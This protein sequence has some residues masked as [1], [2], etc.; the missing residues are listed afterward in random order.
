MRTCM[1]LL[2]CLATA[3]LPGCETSHP[4]TPGR[5]TKAP[6]IARPE[7]VLPDYA[8]L[9]PWTPPVLAER[10]IGAWDFT[11][12]AQNWR[13]LHQATATVSAGVLRVECT[14]D[15]PALEVPVNSG[16][17]PLAVRWR[18]RTTG[19]GPVELF[20]T[21]LERPEESSRQ[22]IRVHTLNDGRWHEYRADVL[23]AGAI[24][25]LRFDPLTAPGIAEL[26]DVRVTELVLHPI[27]FEWLESDGTAVRG[28]VRN[29][30]T[31]PRSITIAG[32]VSRAD[33]GQAI[34]FDIPA[35]SRRPF[36]EIKIEVFAEGLPPLTRFIHR[37]QPSARGDVMTVK[38]GDVRAEV[39]RDGSGA[40]LLWKDHVVAIL[41]PLAQVGNKALPLEPAP[42]AG[43]GIVFRGGPVQRLELRAEGGELHY[44][45]DADPSVTGPAL[46]VLGGLE[47][48]LLAGVEHLG[49]G[50]W[51][52]SRLD[53]DR[54]ERLRYEPAPLL[55]TMPLAAFVTDRGSA[56]LLW[57]DPGIQPMFSAP[58]RYD[59][60]PDHLVALCGRTIHARIR[61]DDSFAA[62]GRLEDAILWAVGRRGLP[63]PPAPPRGPKEERALCL[64]ALTG[65]LQTPAGWLATTWPGAR[66]AFS[67]EHASILWRLTGKV[68]ALPSLSPGIGRVENHAAFL[69]SGRAQVWLRFIHDRARAVRAEQEPDG[70]F[71]YRGPYRR[72]HFEDTASG[73]CARQAVVLLEHA[74]YTGDGGSR[75]AGVRALDYM[76][77]FRTPR[78][79]QT[80]EMPLH[81]PDLAACCWLVRA[82]V[83]GYELTGRADFLAEAR[84]WAVR[85]LPF[86][87]QWGRFPVMRYTA[88][89]A[90]GATD[91]T[92]VV[93]LGLPLPWCG[94]CYGWALTLLAPYDHTFD[95][96]KVARGLLLAAE[97]MQ[98]ADGP[99]AGCLPDSYDLQNQRR[100]PAAI[101]PCEIA[102]LALRLDGQLDGLA[103][104]AEADHRIVAPF[105]VTL[106]RGQATIAGLRGTHY[107]IV[108]DGERIVGIDSKGMDVLHL[109]RPTR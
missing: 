36:E 83:R 92:G 99:Y 69:V 25:A 33:P 16:R 51:S 26:G 31:Q 63:D 2:A 41:A 58:N 34:D 4:T 94:V 100:L 46:R 45:L 57:D 44:R 71:R 62:G 96:P 22:G 108:V 105:P 18:M 42:L 27:H 48:G 37:Y 80:W 72:H 5:R 35:P 102:A 6:A 15:D 106:I 40:R 64:R 67:S 84:R 55:L 77:R 104:A 23:T 98:Y 13:V 76:K 38:A 49:R 87:Y 61:L 74:A 8:R 24:R 93:W 20:L 56:A 29:T 52:S 30:S 68:P 89:G 86:V 82:Y 109:Q 85:G 39:E 88:I 9:A 81:T 32:H 101:A 17:G 14:G 10:P 3:G 78:G 11:S 70:S 19:Q 43:D 54:P 1:L 107:E 12:P 28:A 79:A 53:I 90:L 66:P 75:A 60:T 73:F 97:Q 47:Q 103:V 21:T 50:E 95:W 59:G 65:P 91:W 7:L